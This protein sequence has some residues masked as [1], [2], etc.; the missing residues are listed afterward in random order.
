MGQIENFGPD[1]YLL[2]RNNL[3]LVIRS[4]G[5]DLFCTLYTYRQHIFKGMVIKV[6]TSHP[7]HCPPVFAL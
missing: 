4:S 7:S 1:S 3:S 2:Y 6:R 5:S